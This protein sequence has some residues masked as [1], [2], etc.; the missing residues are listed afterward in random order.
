MAENQANASD[1]AK[2]GLNPNRDEPPTPVE[3]K[4]EKKKKKI[5][6]RSAENKLLNSKSGIME[7]SRPLR[8]K[9]GKKQSMYPPSS[10]RFY[11]AS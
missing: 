11:E 4:V 9:G 6:I 10:V 1:D 7:W 5:R 8:W 2:G 3:I